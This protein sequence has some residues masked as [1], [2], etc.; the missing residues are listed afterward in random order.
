VSSS[1]VIL[2]KWLR[3]RHTCQPLA[4]RAGAEGPRHPLHSQARSVIKYSSC[5]A[6][7]RHITRSTLR[8]Y[9][10]PGDTNMNSM[11]ELAH[12]HPLT[13]RSSFEFKGSKVTKQAPASSHEST[14]NCGLTL[15]TVAAS[16]NIE[17]GYT[18]HGDADGITH[19]WVK[20]GSN[21]GEQWKKQVTIDFMLAICRF[22]RLMTV[23]PVPVPRAQ[24]WVPKAIQPSQPLA[25]AVQVEHSSQLVAQP[26]DAAIP[27]IMLL[28]PALPP[29]EEHSRQPQ[30]AHDV[31]I[32][33]TR[34]LEPALPPREEHSRQ[35]LAALPP[36]LPPREEHVPTVSAP[37]SSQ[38]RQ[39]AP[40][41]LVQLAL[42]ALSQSDVPGPALP[43]SSQ[44]VAAQVSVQPTCL[45]PVMPLLPPAPTTPT[46]LSSTTPPVPVQSVDDSISQLCHISAPALTS[47]SSQSDVHGLALPA[48]SQ[49]L[50][51]QPS[52]QPLLP[53]ASTDRLT[54]LVL[55]APPRVDG[56]RLV[57]AD[58]VADHGAAD[59]AS[60][61]SMDMSDTEDQAE[62]ERMQRATESEAEEIEFM[63]QVRA[64]KRT[65]NRNLPNPS[66][67]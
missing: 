65:S 33:P 49:P 11:V 41:E 62:L 43:E 34:I 24:Q 3:R 40:R 13:L 45:A 18:R 32:P 28:P 23:A 37:D 17:F 42:P 14:Y 56:D 15:L 10:C 35:P 52:V 38:R 63:R 29:R 47:A 66:I 22:S 6:I 26:L 4:A 64:V 20:F 51:A 46:Y 1:P 7:L 53:Q 9:L 50:A 16:W 59:S 31:A 5:G 60:Q 58:E 67:H 36:A 57:W 39:L 27:P 12:H 21:C 55:T 44:P 61:C 54:P 19:A 8:I 30:A 25:A 2:G 48:S